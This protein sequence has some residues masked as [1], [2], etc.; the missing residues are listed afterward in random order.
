VPDWGLQRTR[1]LKPP[2]V[3]SV[4]ILQPR[5]GDLRPFAGCHIGGHTRCQGVERVEV[6]RY[7]RGTETMIEGVLSES[8]LRSVE[9][10]EDLI[11]VQII[12]RAVVQ[13]SRRLTGRDP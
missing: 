7:W 12:P 1:L 11:E 10:G 6:I 8:T 9:C 4:H 5:Q 3:I 13:R 2:E